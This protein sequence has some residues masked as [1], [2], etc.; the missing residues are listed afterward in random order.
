ME[1]KDPTMADVMTALQSIESKIEKKPRVS[2]NPDQAA[3]M[4]GIT[5]KTLLDMTSKKLI[6]YYKP[7]GKMIYF[8]RSELE[9]WLHRNR[10]TPAYEKEK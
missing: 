3:E 9:D 8:D 1:Q 6:P 4:L 7:N 10:Q 5:R 2:L